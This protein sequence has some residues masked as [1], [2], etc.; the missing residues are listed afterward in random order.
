[1]ANVLMIGFPGEG[2]INPSIGV[3][4]EL[5]SR[6]EQITYYAVKEYK[7]KIDALDVEFR[8]YQDFRE[9]HFGKNATGDEERDVTE[10]ICVFLKGCIE[11]VTHIYDEVKHE[12]YDYVI[13][14]HHLLAGKIIANLLKLPRFSLCTTFAMNEEFT[15]QMMGAY[16]KGSLEDSPHYESYQQLAE[17][18]NTDFQAEIK[19]PFDVFLADGDL[20]IVFTS[21]EFQPLAEKFGERY[22]FVGP[23][24]TERAGNKDF[25]FDQIDNE[26]VL[27]ISMGT[28]F[29]NQKHFFN[30][31]LEVCKDFDGKV[32]LSIGK[33]MK[34]SEL[35]DIPENF[36]VRPY[37][38][39][40]EI[41]KRASLFVTH[42]GM[43]ST[44]EGLYFETPLVVIPMG[45]DQF[46]VANQ[47]EKVGA[48]KVLKKEQLSENILKETIQEVMNNHAYSEKAKEIGQSLQAAGRSKK[49]ADC[50]LEFVKHKKQSANA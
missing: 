35:N 9:D 44:S 45:G 34:S 15:K 16:M 19:K 42:G 38:P 21:R 20:T 11:I 40:L 13:Y 32:V 4:K 24:I 18:L 50:I 8:E 27:F 49:A 48:G 33:H 14:D 39:Q 22:V 3:M 2:H 12:S 41:L 23:S 29:N 10:M 46:V 47:V 30:Q 25:P 43:N 5:K 36:I 1:M 7:E 26:N 28:I 31:C 6:G 37:V 17:T